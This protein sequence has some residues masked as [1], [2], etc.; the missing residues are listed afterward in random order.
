MTY[1]ELFHINTPCFFLD[2]EHLRFTYLQ[3]SRRNHPDMV[4][5]NIDAHASAL[6]M[7]AKINQAYTVL[8]SFNKRLA[9]ILELKGLL[10][11]NQKEDLPMDFLMEM[12]DINEEKENN[13]NGE[14]EKEVQKKLSNLENNLTDRCKEYDLT[15]SPNV[16]S[17]IKILYLK[18]Q[19]L[20]RLL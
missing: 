16:L 2:E 19:Y 20:K 6:E 12:M 9:Y 5:H 7:T 11:H 1:F 18:R 14:I 13:K 3:L 8:K 4:M 17:E 10:K 15:Q